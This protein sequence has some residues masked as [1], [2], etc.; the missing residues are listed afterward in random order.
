MSDTFFHR[1]LEL[2]TWSCFSPDFESEASNLNKKRTVLTL[3]SGQVV[4]SVA[5]ITSLRQV[6][7]VLA[8]CILCMVSVVPAAWCRGVTGPVFLRDF[9]HLLDFTTF[10]PGAPVL[11]MFLCRFFSCSTRPKLSSVACNWKP[12]FSWH[13]NVL[14]LNLLYD[15]RR[16]KN[17]NLVAVSCSEGFFRACITLC[18]GLCSAEYSR[19]TLPI[20]L[21]ASLTSLVLWAPDIIVSPTFSSFSWTQSGDWAPSMFLL[22]AQRPRLEHVSWAIKGLNSFVSH[23][24]GFTDFHT[25]VYSV[26]QTI[27]SCILSFCWWLQMGGQ[28]WSLLFRL[29]Q[30]QTF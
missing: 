20:F 6:A 12:V 8:L 17:N 11:P 10:Q 4:S 22:L 16:Q 7:A 3:F 23:L 13:L 2:G 19:G 27:V 21:C 18:A 28:I 15:H 29:D 26:L 25:L 1:L 14:L 9:G 24:S 5:T 30:K